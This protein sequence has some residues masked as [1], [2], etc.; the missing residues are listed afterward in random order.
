VGLTEIPRF[1]APGRRL[2][3]TARRNWTD[4]N[5]NWKV[6]CDLPNGLAQNLTASGGD[7]CG[8]VN[9]LNIGRPVPSTTYA[10]DVLL[11]NREYSW[12]GSISLQQQVMS[13]IALNVGYF[14][15]WYG[16][17]SVTT[18]AALTAANFDTFC[19]TAPTN[20]RLGATSG[21]QIC[22]LYDEKVADFG[23]T[24]S[25]VT[26]SSNFG[27]QTEVFDGVD[28]GVIGRYGRGGIIQGGVSVGRT[29]TDNCDVLANNPQIADRPYILG[30]DVDGF[31]HQ[32]NTNQTQV[33]FAGNYPLPWWGIDASATYQNNPGLTINATR[34]FSRVEARPSLGRNLNDATVTVPIM[35]PFTQ[36][37]D[38]I[39]QLDLRLS[40]RIMIGRARLRGQ[41]DVYNVFNAG[42]ILGESTDYGSNGSSWQRPTSIIGGRL[43]KFGA[44]FEF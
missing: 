37:G 15:T 5:G 6:D 2:A 8:Q 24:N 36:F 19:V 27:D 14:R 38:R 1:N 20:E 40:K 13:G 32:V 35:L 18:N 43:L 44:T 41:F 16:N 4:S 9:N 26:Q 17:L 22:G 39:S 34:A 31:C 23:R 28:I 42:T 29:V 30:G 12:Q 33:K 10:P 7:I 11:D 25:V 21:Q 3:N